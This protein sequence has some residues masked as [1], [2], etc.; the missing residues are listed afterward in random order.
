M[1]SKT[2]TAA[3]RLVAE[4]YRATRNGQPMRWCA[5][6]NLGEAAAD[7]EAI[8]LAALKG[9]IDLEPKNDPHSVTLTDAGRRLVK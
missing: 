4:I 6:S 8:H 5:L 9:W 7:V 1:P 3:R 2:E